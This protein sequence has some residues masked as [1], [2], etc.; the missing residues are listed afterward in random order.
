MAQLHPTAVIEGQVRLGE[1]VSIG[2][3]TWLRGP[4]EIGAGAVIGAH[5]SI[6]GEPEHAAKRGAGGLRI[7]ARTTIGEHVAITRGTGERDTAIGDDCYVMGHCHV[8]HDCVLDDGVIL[9]PGAALAGHTRVHRG[10]NLGVHAATHQRSTIGA[11]AMVG[12]GAV[13]TRDVPPFALVAG[14]PARFRRWNRKALVAAGFSEAALAIRDG[15]LVS[16]DPRVR[17]LL[18]RFTADRRRALLRL[19]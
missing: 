12:M 16:D 15:A 6:G 2:A 4:L 18:A 19:G 5:C 7:G 3:F 1:G 11:Y 14:V 13:V 9:S 8:C 17:E 10:A